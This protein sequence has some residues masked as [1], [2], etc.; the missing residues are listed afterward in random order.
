[1]SE[2]LRNTYGPGDIAALPPTIGLTSRVPTIGGEDAGRAI[3][4]AFPGMKQRRQGWPVQA[5][6]T[7]GFFDENSS[8]V[9]PVA[10]GAAIGVGLAFL[11]R[12]R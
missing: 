3:R 6:S 2:Y 1:M 10:L 11:M 8:W 7:L 12:N 4:P 5:A 9:K